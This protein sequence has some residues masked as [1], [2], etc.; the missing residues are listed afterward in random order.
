M[1]LYPLQDGEFFVNKN[2]VFYDLSTSKNLQGLKIAVRPF[3]VESGNEIVLLDAGLG[4]VANGQQ[5][6]FINIKNSGFQPESISKI[7]L[8][9][10]HKDHIEGLVNKAKE[11][12]KLNFPDACLYIQKRE[13][14]YA[15]SNATS[16][17]FDLVILQFIIDHSNIIWLNDDTGK[18]SETIRYEVS[19]GHTPFHQVF[20]IEEGGNVIFYGADNLP[21][22]DYLKVHIAY[23]SDFDG[24]KA[25][26]ERQKWEQKAKENHWKILLYHDLEKGILEF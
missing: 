4:W 3:L 16:A 23:K 17:S 11:G 9:H 8:S 5:Q 19:G 1:K 26:E 20:W 2:K 13:Y 24:K 6:L 7:L 25:M 10:L 14:E 18:I 22:Q 15:L 12:W 21:T